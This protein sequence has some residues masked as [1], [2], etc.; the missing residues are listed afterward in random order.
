MMICCRPQTRRRRLAL[1]VL[2]GVWAVS[3]VG[4]ASGGKRGWFS[5]E[6]EP[7]KTIADFMKQPRP[8]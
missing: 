8:K 3:A 4:C 7:P 2:L 6:P 5:K 1:I